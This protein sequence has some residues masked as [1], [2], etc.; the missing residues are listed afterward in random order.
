MPN[1]TIGL[2][3]K[4]NAMLDRLQGEKGFEPTSLWNNS[5]TPAQESAGLSI[6]PSPLECLEEWIDKSIDDSN[7]G[8]RL[9]A[10]K[11]FRPSAW[12]KSTY[13][14]TYT[15]LYDAAEK[16]LVEDGLLVPL[17]LPTPQDSVM[18]GHKST[19]LY[20]TAEVCRW[21]VN[22]EDYINGVNYKHLTPLS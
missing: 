6:H 12:L 14:G 19:L 1:M 7:G 3:E 10:G 18:Q 11:W 21:L 22:A 15:L 5:L 8:P 9:I 2:Q 20:R 13:P 4:V 17:S 16:A